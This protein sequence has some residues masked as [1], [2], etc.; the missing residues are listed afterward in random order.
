MPMFKTNP[1]IKRG[2]YANDYQ[3]KFGEERNRLS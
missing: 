3:R 2:E 1:H